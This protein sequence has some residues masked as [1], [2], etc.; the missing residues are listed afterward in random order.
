MVGRYLV[1]FALPGEGEVSRLGIT[2][3][4]KIGGAVVRNRARRRIRELARAHREL[5]EGWTGDLVV[6]VRQGCDGA[7]WQELSADFTRCL[8]KVRRVPPAP[9]S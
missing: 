4:R 8:I 2:A 3:T 9:A 6:N 7:G 1:V 5:L